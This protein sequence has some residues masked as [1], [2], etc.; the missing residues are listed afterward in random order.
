MLFYIVVFRAILIR[1]RL[2]GIFAGGGGSVFVSASVL[3]VLRQDLRWRWRRGKSVCA[4]ASAL[5]ASL[6]D[7]RG[8]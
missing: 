4:A 1:S 2:G 6:G 8:G 5:D 3:N 7:R